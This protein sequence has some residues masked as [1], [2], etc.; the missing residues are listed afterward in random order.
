MPERIG[1]PGV[2]ALDATMAGAGGL[3]G[4]T[5][6]SPQ[7]AAAALAF[8]FARYGARNLA[9]SEALQRNLLN[10]S[11]V[12]PRWAMGAGAGAMAD[13]EQE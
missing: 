13:R 1:G 7:T 11:R 5:M 10:P 3:L 2:S 6:Q 12:P 4:I 8:P 9:L